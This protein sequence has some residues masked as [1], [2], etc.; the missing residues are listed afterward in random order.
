AHPLVARDR[1]GVGVGEDMADVQRA[2]HRRRRRVDRVD[3]LTWSRAVE[4]VGALALPRLAPLALEAVQGGLLGDAGGPVCARRGQ[5]L[6][7]SAEARAGRDD[8]ARSQTDRTNL[9][10]R[11]RN[12][13]IL[14]NRDCFSRICRIRIVL[15][16]RLAGGVGVSWEREA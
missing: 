1:V 7:V 15:Q 14:P 12:L 13:T 2:A 10:K 5:A 6:I 11:L 8:P 4:R 16:G 9:G 3:A